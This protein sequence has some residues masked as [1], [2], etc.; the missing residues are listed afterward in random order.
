M[1]KKSVIKEVMDWILVLV[2]AAFI[3][4]VI[5]NFVIVNCVVPSASMEQTIMTGDR[6]IGFRLAYLLDDPERGDIVIFKYPD[7]ENVLYIKRVIGM[8]G[9]TVE[10]KDGILYINGEAYSEDYLGSID[11][12]SYGPYK[13]P[14]DSYLMLGDNRANSKDSRFWNHTY[15]SRDKIVGK[16]LFKYWPSFTKL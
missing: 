11:M 13:V 2:I 1:N 9:D 12:N 4:I 5:N 3:A 8:P 10:L 16:A 7:D 14:D 6:A 15:V